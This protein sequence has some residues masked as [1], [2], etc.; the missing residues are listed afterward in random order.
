MTLWAGICCSYGGKWFGGWIN[1][2][3]ENRRLKTV[4]YLTTK[5]KAEMVY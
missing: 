5:Q 2:Y 1:D 3:K 4:D